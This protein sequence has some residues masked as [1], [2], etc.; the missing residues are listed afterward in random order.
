MA[1]PESKLPID[2]HETAARA[3]VN[4]RCAPA[5][6]HDIRG[7][8]QAL[9]SAIELLTRAARSAESD[10]ERLAK[11]ADLARRA[12]QRHEET[13]MDVVQLLTMQRSP[14]KSLDWQALLQNSVEFLRND[15]ARNDLK[16]RVSGEAGLRVRAD[17]PA[18]QSAVL[19]VLTAVIDAMSSGTELIVTVEQRGDCAAAIISP[20]PD[21]PW[22][23]E[24]APTQPAPRD[25]RAL[26]LLF[27]RR[28]LL[29]N[30]GRLERE[31][32]PGHS[33]AL[34]VLYPLES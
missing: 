22:M 3:G 8:M 27:A 16:A 19:D 15:L 20:V 23:D 13:T 7:S 9:F 32:G 17:R 30:G 34:C 25:R 24:V 18:M 2:P 28:F 6:L 14:A 4:E 10:P 5:L 26:P 33:G 29:A 11:C 31:A 12:A 1:L 21:L